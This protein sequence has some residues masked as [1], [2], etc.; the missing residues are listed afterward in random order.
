MATTD[1]HNSKPAMRTP[2]RNPDERRTSISAHIVRSVSVTMSH[3]EMAT[4]IDVLNM[5][6]QVPL[7]IAEDDVV[8]ELTERVSEAY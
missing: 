2:A 3:A 5:R 8:R 7:S 4:L 6:G 1:S